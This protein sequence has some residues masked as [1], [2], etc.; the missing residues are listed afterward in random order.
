MPSIGKIIADQSPCPMSLFKN[1]I[2]IDHVILCS[3]SCEFLVYITSY[4]RIETEC[5]CSI[6][7][8]ALRLEQIILSERVDYLGGR[9][10]PG[11]IEHVRAL[12]VS[13]R[14][15]FGKS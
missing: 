13:N 1:P 3:S 8:G 5:I 10:N 12:S 9:G 7:K 15:A 2:M 4:S 11:A 6:S 14:S